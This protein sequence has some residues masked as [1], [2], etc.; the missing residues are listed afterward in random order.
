[1]AAAVPYSA[2]VCSLHLCVGVTS[3]QSEKDVRELKELFDAFDQYVP[4]AARPARW[5]AGVC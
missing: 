1:M 4:R 2:C 3:A 5:I